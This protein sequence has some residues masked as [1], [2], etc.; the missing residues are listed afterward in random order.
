VSEVDTETGKVDV[1]EYVAVDDCGVVVNPQI[2]EGQIHG[3]VA[4]G[5]AEA[6]FEEARYD[7]NGNLMTSNMQSYLVPSAA[8]LPS[9]VLDRTETPST[10]NPLGV[11]GVGEAGTI[12]APPAVVNSVVDALSHLG[13]TDVPKPATPEAVW[14]AIHSAKGAPGWHAAGGEGGGA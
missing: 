6:L 10:T 8:E 3:G 2:V 12:A 13:V 14:R 4:Q 7:E 11:K 1:V 5:I 9:F